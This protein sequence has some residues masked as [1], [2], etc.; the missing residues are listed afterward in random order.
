MSRVAH[1]NLL[2]LLSW[3]PLGIAFGLG[4]QSV[5]DMVHDTHSTGL[6][7]LFGYAALVAVA[8][9]VRHVVFLIVLRFD[10]IVCAL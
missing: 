4:W 10:P 5:A 1:A 2:T 3:V 6:V 9:V 7:I 8:I